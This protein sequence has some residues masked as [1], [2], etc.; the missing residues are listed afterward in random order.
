LAGS[1]ITSENFPEA[2]PDGSVNV[3]DGLTIAYLEGGAGT[4]TKPTKFGNWTKQP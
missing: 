4:Y 3:G 2:F 1:A